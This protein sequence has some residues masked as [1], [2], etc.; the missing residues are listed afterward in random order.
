MDDAALA[1]LEV[2]RMLRC[3]GYRFTAVTPETQRRVN[4]RAAVGGAPLARDLRDVFGWNRSFDPQLL[5]AGL[6]AALQAAGAIGR[7]GD[8]LIS[9]VRFASLGERLFAHSAFPTVERDAVFFGPDS[10]RFC[11]LVERW[12]PGAHAARLVDVGCGSGVGGICAARHAR[13]IVLA[14]VNAHA[15][16]L[17]E[18]NAALNGVSAEIVAS[19]VLASIAEPIDAVIANP[20]YMRDAEG[21]TYRDGGGLHGEALSVRIVREALARLAEHGALVL[22]TGSAI[23]DG[24]DSFWHAVLPVLR[25][26]DRPYRYQELD[27][28]VFGEELERPGYERVERIAVVGLWVGGAGATPPP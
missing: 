16:R 12:L 2:G 9:R 11:A 6:L 27:P 15:L 10:Q 28:D 4:A 24:Q 5:P 8:R 18:V 23:V 26:S 3:S 19:D 20:P 14:D 7:N 1:L 17:A 21:R 13:R 22:Y 25:E